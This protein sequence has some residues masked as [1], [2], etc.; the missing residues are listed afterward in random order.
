MKRK[1]SSRTLYVVLGCIANRPDVLWMQ[2]ILWGS[3]P[4]Y[5]WCW[6]WW[7]ILEVESAGTL[8]WLLWCSGGL[9]ID[10]LFPQLLSLW[11]HLSWCDSVGGGGVTRARASPVIYLP[12][13][14]IGE[15]N[16]LFFS[17]TRSQ[18]FCYGNRKQS[19][20]MSERENKKQQQNKIKVKASQTW[21]GRAL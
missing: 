3:M 10:V 9:L 6:R 13:K 20:A 16:L 8:W 14:T 19:T 4:Q 17:V 12:F 2:L 21:S 7:D 15:V 11:C 18:A 5:G 1:L